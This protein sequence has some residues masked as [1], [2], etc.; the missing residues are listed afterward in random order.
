M[1]Y[2]NSVAAVTDPRNSFQIRKVGWG[3]SLISILHVNFI[4]C[5]KCWPNVRF[6]LCLRIWDLLSFFSESDAFVHEKPQT[7]VCVPALPSFHKTFPYSEMMFFPSLAPLLL[8]FLILTKLY[9]YN[10]ANASNRRGEHYL[11]WAKKVGCGNQHSTLLFQWGRFCEKVV[12]EGDIKRT[13]KP[14][15]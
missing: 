10:E 6:S 15:F 2:S 1:I 8:K 11:P 7:P 13:G 9:G 14:M 4:L 12:S 3:H 5:D